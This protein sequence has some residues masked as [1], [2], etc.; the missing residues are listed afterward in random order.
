MSQFREEGNDANHFKPWIHPRKKTP[1]FCGNEVTGFTDQKGNVILNSKGIYRFLKSNKV[2][3]KINDR[4]LV[5]S[6][7]NISELSFIQKMGCIFD[8][9][10]AP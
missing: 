9:M 2:R 4:F 5:H 8:F 6:K 1:L 7:R 3:R 10:G